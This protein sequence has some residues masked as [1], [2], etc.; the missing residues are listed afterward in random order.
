METGT[1]IYRQTS[2]KKTGSWQ[3]PLTEVLI[4]KVINGESFGL[5]KVKYVPGMKTFFAEDIS[6]NLTGQNIWFENGDL[7]VP[8]ADIVKNELLQAHPW[9]GKHFELFSKDAIDT[10]RLSA[11]RAKNNA[12]KL[13]EESDKEKIK[14]IALAVFGQAA[15]I[16]S[17]DTCELELLQYADSDPE[18]LERE[19]ADKNYESRYIAALAFSKN[20][21]KANVGKTSVIW[22]DTT[23]GVIL[24][25]AKGESGIHK[26]GEL[27]SVNNEGSLLIMQEISARLEKL[28]ITPAKIQDDKDKEIEA[29]KAE[30]LKIKQKETPNPELEEAIKQFSEKF[31]KVVPINKK[32]DLDW[33]LSKLN[34]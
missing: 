14:A 12:R 24:R 28:E 7:R 13:I 34:E 30:L 1:N 16:W 11:L 29:L 10:K 2:G 22:N 21:V 25:L 18:K 20:I 6:D 26:L 17:E 23:E 31:N 8:K 9:F 4:E 32:N 33:I 19:L 15:F 3:L 27:L 5:S